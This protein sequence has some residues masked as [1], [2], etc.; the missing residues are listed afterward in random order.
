MVT[1]AFS[2]EVSTLKSPSV[3]Q[4]VNTKLGLD[5]AALRRVIDALV[6]SG[7][8]GNLYG[9]DAWS[10]N[11]DR[12]VGNILVAANALPWLIDHGR[13]F[14]GQNWTSGDL[15]ADQLFTSRLKAWLTPSLSKAQKDEYATEA[16]ELATQLAVLDV[17][18]TGTKNGLSY[19]YGEGDFNALV[20]FLCDRIVHT[21]RIASDSLGLVI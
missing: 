16:A 9:F 15:V 14:T 2:S 18:E 5:V 21:P 12:H 11:I 4:I 19:L 10:A 8:L 1:K 20:T 13:C 6:L 7:R 3:A 17:R